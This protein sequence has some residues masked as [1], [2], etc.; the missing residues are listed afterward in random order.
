MAITNQERVGKA[1]DHLKDGLRPFV[2]REMQATFG[3]KW[4]QVADEGF[5]NVRAK[6]GASLN[7]PANLLSILLNEWSRVFEKTLGK[8]ERNAVHSLKEVR[9]KWAHG[10]AFSSDEVYRAID[11]AGLLLA[12]V[13]APQT[14]EVEK[15]KME[16]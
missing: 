5:P 6:G 8:T 7:D 10:E 13:A 16:L 4:K 1:L 3:E 14:D 9:N 11:T 2:E 12:A 15:M